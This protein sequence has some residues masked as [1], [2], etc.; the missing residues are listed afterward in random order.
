MTDK[1]FSVTLWVL[2]MIGAFT[3]GGWLIG[4]VDWAQRRITGRVTRP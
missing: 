3:L 1:I 2:A 4:V